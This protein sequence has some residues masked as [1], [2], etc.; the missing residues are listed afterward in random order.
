MGKVFFT[1]SSNDREYNFFRDILK[2]CIY[3]EMNNLDINKNSLEKSEVV[4]F[5]TLR[6]KLD[7]ADPTIFEKTYP[8]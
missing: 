8:I 2:E 5:S 1:A 7:H 6:Q 4:T 3:P